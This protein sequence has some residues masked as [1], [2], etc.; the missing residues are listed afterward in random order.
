MAEAAFDL[1]RQAEDSEGNGNGSQPAGLE[2]MQAIILA[3]GKGTRLAPYTSVLPKPLMPVGD[4]AILELVVDQLA[5]SGVTKVSFCVGYLAHLIRAVFD[6]RTNGDV[7]IVYV[8]EAEALGTAAPLRLVDGLD[9]TS[10]V[11][12]GDVL[13]TLDY[14]DLVRYHKASG[15]VLTIA[16]HERSIKI[17]YGMLHL[18]VSERVRDFEEKPQILSPVSMGI[19]VMEPSVL[20]YIPPRGHFD[21][22]DLVRALLR[23]DERVGA[24]RFKGMWFDIGRA[25]DY[26]RAVDA[27]NA[28]H[29]AEESLRVHETNGADT[30]G[31]GDVPQANGLRPHANGGAANANGGAPH[32]NGGVPHTNGGAPHTNGSAPH[33]IGGDLRNWTRARD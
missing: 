30:N 24:Y 20:D 2:D 29:H 11:M 7:E 18:D 21:F 22:P 15:N 32:S 6:Q 25:D 31:N 14:G 26:A 8:H 10:I 33:R 19:Y 12:N 3:G 13:T 4:R 9:A 16:T 28:A 1:Y 17:D 5:A 23:T 27:W